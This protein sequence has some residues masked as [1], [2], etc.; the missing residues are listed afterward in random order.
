MSPMLSRRSAR[1]SPLSPTSLG[2]RV[3]VFVIV[4]ELLFGIV[5]GITVGLFAARNAAQHRYASARQTSAVVAASVMPSIADQN[6]EAV[7][8]QLDSIMALS[9]SVGVSC[10]RILDSS[11][12]VL[13]TSGTDAECANVRANGAPV[14]DFFGAQFVDEPVVVDG[15]EIGRVQM[16]FEAARAQETVGIPLLAAAI[17]I[18]AVVLVSAP[19]TAWLF[20]RNILVPVDE[21]RDGAIAVAGGRRDLTLSHGRQDELGEL[22]QAFDDMSRQLA[23]QENKL[24]ESHAALELALQSEGSARVEIERAAKMKSEFVAVASHELRAPIAVVRLYAEMLAH[25]EMGRMSKAARESVSAISGAANRLNSI[26]SDLMDAAL[27]ERGL[28]PLEF[29]PLRLDAV[30]RQATTESDALSATHGVR[31]EVAGTLPSAL[32]KGDAVRVRQVLDNLISNAVKYSAGAELVTVSMR[33]DESCATVEVSDRGQ[34]IDPEGHSRLF[35]LFSRLDSEDNRLTAGLG[36]GLAISAR[37]ADA[38]AGAVSHRDNPGGGSVF[39]FSIPLLGAIDDQPDCAM[40][41]VSE[42]AS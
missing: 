26:V 10:I 2:T 4:G 5:L 20:V 9:E 32:V 11:G 37:V 31:V 13:A 7:D 35:G 25:G 1:I 30:V 28:M 21:L 22:A 38:H 24:N 27:L 19:W 42:E 40:F 17:V 36:L 41:S 33:V 14:N 12:Q 16:R 15:L 8:A 23:Q 34:G 29:R 6:S 3:L 18:L 39:S